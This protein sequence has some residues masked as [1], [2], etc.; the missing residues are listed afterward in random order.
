MSQSDEG[1]RQMNDLGGV[2][3]KLHRATFHA[4][5]LLQAE[6]AFRLRSPWTVAE[7]KEDDWHVF[8]AVIT[9]PAPLSLSVIM[10][11][12][13][14]QMRSSLDHLATAAARLSDPT[15]REVHF[16]FHRQPDQFDKWRRAHA[17]HMRAAHIDVIGRYQPF[18]TKAE[19]HLFLRAIAD[20]DNQAKHEVIAAAYAFTPMVGFGGAAEVEFLHPESIEN[21]TVLCRCRPKLGARVIT[22]ISI[23]LAYGSPRG[24][25]RRSTLGAIEYQVGQ[26]VAEVRAVTP[27]WNVTPSV[28]RTGSS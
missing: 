7:S 8:R 2:Y 22:T 5:E 1:T 20:F 18:A 17:S 9:R 3:A 10:G 24:L 27:E 16:P 28:F 6:A 19:P 23:E 4:D 26:I 14:H 25:L 11:E 12:A 15:V 21:G 13:L